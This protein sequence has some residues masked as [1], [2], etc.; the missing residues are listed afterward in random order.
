MIH[1]KKSPT[2]DTRTCDVSQVS[3]EQ[4]LNSSIQHIEDVSKGLLFFQS[5]I[6]DAIKKHDY[7]KI[8][9]ID[10]FY[11][12]FQNDFKTTEWWDRHRKLNRHHLLVEDGIPEDVNL[13]DVLELIVDCVMAGL[14]RT[15][16]VYNLDLDQD[17]L[18]KAFENT[19]DLLKN[20]IEVKDND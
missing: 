3:K 10:T 17:V 5:L 15:G 18:K 19:I 1:I 14:A 9:D 16:Y 13:I 11:K 6:N 2:A 7:D 12:D 8:S 20:N 4:L